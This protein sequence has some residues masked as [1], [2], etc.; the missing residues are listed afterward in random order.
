MEC[1]ISPI[2][3]DSFKRSAIQESVIIAVDDGP[4]L[5]VLVMTGKLF[6]KFIMQLPNLTVQGNLV[7]EK[8]NSLTLILY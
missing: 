8:I 6:Q 1:N 7:R 3:E 2:Q 5:E 4:V